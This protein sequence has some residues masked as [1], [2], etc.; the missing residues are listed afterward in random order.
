[1]SNFQNYSGYYD[2]LYKDKNYL[3]E[4]KYVRN[5][6][7]NHLPNCN[8]ILELGCGSGSHARYLTEFGFRI[9]GLEKSDSMVQ[10][11]NNKEILNFK[12]EVADIVDFKLDEK[13]DAVI[14]LFH[15][16]SYLT[17]SSDLLNSLTCVNSH[18]DI[19]GIF[20]FDVWFTPAVYNLKPETRCK[21]MENDVMKVTRISVP[22]IDYVSSVVSVVFDI[23]VL[24]K[25]SN[26]Y[27]NI[28]EIHPMRHFT[29]NE[30]RFICSQKGFEIVAFEEFLS[31]EPLSDKTWGATIIC[32][33]IFN[34]K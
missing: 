6:L 18:L 21:L 4:A 22:E 27:S 2:L 25:K 12:A 16:Y 24:D 1:M 5:V 28:Q 10:L 32:K 11:A 15:V 30:L 17:S 3:E 31:G 26:E 7:V 19:G 9:T 14:S 20:L 29:I 8:K 34:L 13:F 33:K 23:F